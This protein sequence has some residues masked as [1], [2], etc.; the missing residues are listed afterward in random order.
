MQTRLIPALLTVLAAVTL[1]G[2]TDDSESNV[3]A[4]QRE[5]VDE[6]AA[7]FLDGNPNAVAA[8]FTEDGVYEERGPHQVFEGHPA[9]QT[10]LE[11]GFE[12]A[13]ATEMTADSVIAGD[14]VLG[15]DDVIVVEWT[16]AGMSAPGSRD[17]ADKTPF[18]VEAVTVFEMEDGLIARSVFYAPW[19]DLFN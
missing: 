14:A 8:L 12:Y 6:W 3:T 15:D 7:A 13:D 16:M 2:C 1:I 10:Q 18:S 11:E 4:S 5:V 19:D 17:P 9:I